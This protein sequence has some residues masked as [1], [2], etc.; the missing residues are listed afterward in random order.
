[1]GKRR[2]NWLER[3]RNP[4]M[5]MT[6]GMQTECKLWSGAKDKDG[7]GVVKIGGRTRRVH[8]VLCEQITGRV[9]EEGKEWDHLCN[10]RAC[11]RWEHLEEVTH[12]ENVR[13][14]VER[15]RAPN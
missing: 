6:P 10:Q 5:K 9:L 3:T 11:Y 1:M 8:V 15:R 4:T 7:Y 2:R 13:R 12:E 14:A